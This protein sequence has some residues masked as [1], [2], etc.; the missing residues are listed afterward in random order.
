M[1]PERLSIITHRSSNVN[2]NFE[3]I[4]ENSNLLSN[5]LDFSCLLLN[6]HIRIFL[7]SGGNPNNA[8]TNGS[9]SPL[10]GRL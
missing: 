10:R 1:S 5:A 4:Y 9:R 2:K 3:K 6:A 8:E 7:I